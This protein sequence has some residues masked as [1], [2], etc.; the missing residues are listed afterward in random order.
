MDGTLHPE[1]CFRQIGA[2]PEGHAGGS[3]LILYLFPFDHSRF[4]VALHPGARF[5]RRGRTVARKAKQV[6]HVSVGG[7]RVGRDQQRIEILLWVVGDQ[8]QLGNVPTAR[9]DGDMNPAIRERPGALPVERRLAQRWLLANSSG[10]TGEQDGHSTLHSD[11]ISSCEITRFLY[12]WR[13]PPFVPDRPIE[14]LSKMIR[15]VSSE[16]SKSLTSKAA[17]TST[18]S[19]G[20][21]CISNPVRRNLAMS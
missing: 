6:T 1:L 4:A 18:T 16:L 20:S 3:R 5:I 7:L 8:T 14:R 2:V 19:I 12:F 15:C 10:R 17:R 11:S 9:H 13:S 21:W